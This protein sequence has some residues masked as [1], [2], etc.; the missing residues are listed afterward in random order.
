MRTVA[1][2]VDAALNQPNPAE[3]LSRQSLFPWQKTHALKDVQ[4]AAKIRAIPRAT[5]RPG[6]RE[7]GKAGFLA[8]ATTPTL[9]KAQQK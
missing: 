6:A 3:W 9:R 7:E 4:M 2:A 8:E 5:P 1:E